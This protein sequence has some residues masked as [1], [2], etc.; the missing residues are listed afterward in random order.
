MKATRTTLL[1]AAL[2]GLILVAGCADDAA[3]DG[4]ETQSSA[5]TGKASKGAKRMTLWTGATATDEALYLRGRKPLRTEPAAPWSAWP[6]TRVANTLLS[7]TKACT[8]ED[9]LTKYIDYRRRLVGDGTAANPGFVSVGLGSGQSLPASGRNPDTVTWDGKKGA[10]HFGDTT[11]HHGR[12]LALLGSE[13]RAFELMGVDTDATNTELYY[14]LEAFNRLDRDSETFYGY[15]PEL[16]GFFIRDD[17]PVGFMTLANGQPRF[18]HATSSTGGYQVVN[19]QVGAVTS[20]GD[21]MS[22]DQVVGL[23]FGLAIVIEMVDADTTVSGVNLRHEA[24][25]IMH[26]IITKVKRD[27]WYILDPDGVSPPPAWGGFISYARS[28][29]QIA[30]R[31]VG[32]SHGVASY[33]AGVTTGHLNDTWNLWGLVGNDNQ[34]M[35]LSQ[36]AILPRYNSYTQDLRATNRRGELLPLVREAMLGDAVAGELEDW[37]IEGLLTS[38][39]CGGPCNGTTGCVGADGWKSENRF[40]H[41]RNRNGNFY[42]GAGESPGVDY[43]LLHNFYLIHKQGAYDAVP[44]NRPT[45]GCD[46]VTALDQALAGPGIDHYD[47]GNPC[48]TADLSRRFCGRSFA[49]WLKDASAGDATIWTPGKRWNCTGAG[50]CTLSAAGTAGGSGP[51]LIFGDTGADFIKGQGGSDCIYGGGGDDTI[52]GGRGFD[53]IHGGDGDDDLYGEWPGIVTQGESDTLYGGAGS[54]FIRGNLGADDLFG[55]TGHDD[56][57]G[58]DGGDVIVGG[59]GN[60]YIVGGNGDDVIRAEDGNDTLIGGNGNDHLNAGAGDDHVN[61]GSGDDRAYAG[62]GFDDLVMGTGNDAASARDEGAPNAPGYNKFDCGPGIDTV[63]GGIRRN[64]VWGGDGDDFIQGGP[65]RDKIDGGAGHDELRGMGGDDF[66]RGATGN[67]FILGGAG[68]DRLCGNEQHD[69]IDVLDMND[70]YHAGLSWIGTAGADSC[71]GGMG[72]NVV[73]GACAWVPVSSCGRPALLNW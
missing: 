43:M 55:G 40:I 17:V 65:D 13:V 11:A 73:D 10:Y 22:L 38:A 26:R 50:T 54:D 56:I 44:T 7:T 41:P 61:A 45:R 47:A 59:S 60:D 70:P 37:Q 9:W 67:D 35:L 29:A 1:N 34:H 25:A 3:F 28:L 42:G 32:N 49:S 51:D 20:G 64:E 30:D 16:N 15:Q 27:N 8:Q 4:F 14:A 48:T 5:L 62:P 66:I 2:C 53:E 18:P 68:D 19:E 23:F 31:Y 36:A 6:Q 57:A 12:Y 46:A 69:R 63:W 71:S 33:S 58:G 52:W 39:P 21:A 24:Q 72:S